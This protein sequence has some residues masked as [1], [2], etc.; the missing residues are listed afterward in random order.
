MYHG[1]KIIRTRDDFTPLNPERHGRDNTGLCFV[2]GGKVVK[3]IIWC[4]THS[5]GFDL[6]RKSQ[7]R[8]STN[9]EDEI[10]Y[11]LDHPDF[12]GYGGKPTVT[13]LRKWLA[14]VAERQTQRS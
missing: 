11:T 1:T 14:P 5:E 9:V 8:H 7:P 3:G 6:W 2:C 12:N 10:R 13:F 4:R